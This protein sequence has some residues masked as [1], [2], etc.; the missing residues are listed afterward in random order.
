MSLRKA[1]I[2]SLLVGFALGL[3]LFRWRSW[4]AT[5][6]GVSYEVYRWGLIHHVEADWDFDGDP[7]LITYEKAGSI[8]PGHHVTQLGPTNPD[9]KEIYWRVGPIR[10]LRMWFQPPAQHNVVT[11]E[12]ELQSGPKV[13]VVGLDSLCLLLRQIPLPP[14]GYGPSVE[15][16]GCGR[17]WPFGYRV[18]CLGP[19]PR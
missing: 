13:A 18:Q 8:L 6:A 16:V 7:D 2:F 10:R 19:I 15:D 4:T 3:W 17:P 9:Y 5:A 1:W 14:P 12:I 11:A